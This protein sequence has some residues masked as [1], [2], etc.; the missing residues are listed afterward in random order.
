MAENIQDNELQEEGKGKRSYSKKFSEEEVNAIVAKAVAEALAK[1]QASQPQTVV[2]V[3]QDEY[4]TILYIGANAE[5]TTVAMPKWGQ[6][7]YPGGM[8]D[9]PKKEFMQG[10]GIPVN[11][12][13]LRERKIIVVSG[14]TDAEKMR[15][16]VEYKDGELL[17]TEAFFSLI[18]YDTEKICG[19]FAHLCDEHKRTVA[20]LYMTAYFDK[21]DNRINREKVKA[22]NELS[23]TV[24]KDGLFTPILEDMNANDL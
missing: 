1:A 17:T 2:Q 4:V 20:K 6:I 11:T 24:E 3:A 10:L 15:F 22:L 14:L 19:I 9:V 12:A 7:T 13:L 18:G 5:G 21:K 16:G 8:I 23:K